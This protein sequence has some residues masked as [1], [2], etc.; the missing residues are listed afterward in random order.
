METKHVQY[1]IPVHIG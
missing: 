1:F